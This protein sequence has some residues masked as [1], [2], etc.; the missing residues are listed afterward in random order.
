VEGGTWHARRGLGSPA[1]GG[2]HTG[3]QGDGI[4]V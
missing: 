1:G 3:E 4:G 2:G